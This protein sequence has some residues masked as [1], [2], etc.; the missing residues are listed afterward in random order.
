MIVTGHYKDTFHRIDGIWHFESRTMFVDQVGEIEL[1]HRRRTTDLGCTLP[2]QVGVAHG[3]NHMGAGLGESARRA[4][5]D[6]VGCSGH[7][8]S[9]AGQVSQPV[10]RPR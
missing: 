1:E 8:D 5:P 6:A 3:Q 2:T 7:N 9:F 10:R 4:Q